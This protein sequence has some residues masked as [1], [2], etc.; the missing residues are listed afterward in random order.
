VRSLTQYL[1]R[2]SS[3]A[4]GDGV[5]LRAAIGRRR[6]GEGP[7]RPELETLAREVASVARYVSGLKREI[8]ALRANEIYRDRLPEAHGDLHRIRE[9]T[10]SS[11]NRIMEAGEA[12]LSSKA[13]TLEGYRAETEEKVLEIFEACSFQDITG[14]R[15]AR[16]DEMIGQIERRLQ[17]FALAVKA[18]DGSGGYDRE[19]I[20][21]EARREVLIVEGPQNTDGCDQT[22]IDKLFDSDAPN[23]S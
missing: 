5:A 19:A 17:R 13:T 12:I 11:V 8:G 6:A 18:S 15:V 14:Q 1:R 10:A 2:R 23:G 3:D 21:R 4:D 20:L 22:D 16:V 7:A 9:T